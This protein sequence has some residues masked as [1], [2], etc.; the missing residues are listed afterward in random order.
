MQTL[1]VKAQASLV[2]VISTAEPREAEQRWDRDGLMK[3]M[4]DFVGVGGFAKTSGPGPPG[5]F[6]KSTVED[7][8]P[9]MTLRMRLVAP[10]R[11]LDLESRANDGIVLNLAKINFKEIR[12]CPT[13][14]NEGRNIVFSFVGLFSKPQFHQ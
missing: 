6:W 13:N 3:G 8:L 9:V 10:L 1:G 14:D 7:R 4:G 5:R 2:L 12:F 11:L